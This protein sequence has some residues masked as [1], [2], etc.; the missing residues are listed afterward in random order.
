MNKE[1]RDA[2]DRLLLEQGEYHPLELL[3]AECRLDFSDYESW[4]AGEIPRLEQVLFGDPEQ[5]DQ[6]LAEAE[7]Y[8]EALRL[9][10]ER[11]TYRGWGASGGAPLSYSDN[12]TREERFHTAYRP[13]A[14]QPQMDLFI[15]AAASR[16]VNGIVQS[17][18]AR[19]YAE[20]GRL[21]DR[22]FEADPGNQ[23]LGAQEQM[24]EAGSRLAGPV[25]DCEQELRYLQQ[26]LQPMAERELGRDSSSLL[27]PHWRRLSAALQGRPLDDA[28]PELHASFTA[29]RAFDWEGAVKAAECDAAWPGHPLLLSRY[30]H[31]CGRLHREVAALQAWF[32][33]C[34][35]FPDHAAAIATGADSALQR[36]WREFVALEPALA[37]ADFPAWLLLLR[38][39]L[40][41]QLD[42]RDNGSGCPPAYLL[43]HRLQTEDSRNQAAPRKAAIELRR[44]LRELSPDLFV[45]YMRSRE[46]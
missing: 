42:A 4:R 7:K 43:V 20:A 3:L 15:D 10:P 32:R 17:L 28:Q 26:T 44:Q 14:Q 41:G 31:A 29:I 33:L 45:H 34:W 35:S 13:L 36:S 1:I 2:V 27:V 46:L 18:T 24:V 6:L 25:H 30:A 22:L 21:L 16:L 8:A 19:D 40:A 23:R 39:G 9:A 5:L 11:L 38:P 37:P 12:G